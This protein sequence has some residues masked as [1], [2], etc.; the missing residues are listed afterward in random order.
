MWRSGDRRLAIAAFFVPLTR[1][2][3]FIFFIVA[4]PVAKGIDYFLGEDRMQLFRRSE[5][6]KLLELHTDEV[7]SR[8][9]RMLHG[10]LDIRHKTAR[11]VMVPWKEVF[12]MPA[13]C[14][15]S[16]HVRVFAPRCSL[17]S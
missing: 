7:G 17:W 15:V 13:E 1:F 8:E 12:K 14:V 3:M 9:T 5:L 4:W 16:S 2:L 6:K 11:D 10:V